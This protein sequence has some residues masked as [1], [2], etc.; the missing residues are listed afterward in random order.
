VTIDKGAAL[1]PD[2]HRRA[3]LEG[4]LTAEVIGQQYIL[5]M[6]GARMGE[7]LAYALKPEVAGDLK[8][9][10]GRV[11]VSVERILE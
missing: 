6:D 8:R 9:D 10:F 5:L 7:L 2:T 3:D 1:I 11:R 4:L